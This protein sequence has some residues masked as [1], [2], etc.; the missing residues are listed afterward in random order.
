MC[1]GMYGLTCVFQKIKLC[2]SS[3]RKLIIYFYTPYYI[4]M[5]LYLYISI[6]YI[7]KDNIFDDWFGYKIVKAS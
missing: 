2:Y 1:V 4:S 6:I 5:Y 3:P 7:Y